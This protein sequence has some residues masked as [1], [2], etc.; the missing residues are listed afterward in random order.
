MSTKNTSKHLQQPIGIMAILVVCGTIL[1]SSYA[2]AA[3]T[4]SSEAAIAE[5]KE[6]LGGVPTELQL[7][8]ESARAAGWA[9]M[10][11]TDLN[12]NTALPSKVRELIGLA[13]AA[14]IPCEYCVYYHIKA[15]RTA[16]ASQEEIREAV[17]Q[18]GLTRHWSTILYGNQYSLDAY[19][20]EIDA[21][22]K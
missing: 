17:H 21:A 5:M 7:Y 11:S 14:Q 1:A 4:T 15:A 10:K 9:M 3:D 6:M 22:F 18:A 12:E 16:G 19:K 20:T 13:V 2:R 8:P